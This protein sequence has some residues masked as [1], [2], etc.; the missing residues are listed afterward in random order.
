MKIWQTALE[1]AKLIISTVLTVSA[2][3]AGSWTIITNT[4]ITRSEAEAQIQNFTAEIA[5]NKAF[6]LETKI[7]NLLEIKKRRELSKLE[8]KELIRLRKY[9]TQVDNHLESI[10]LQMFGDK[11]D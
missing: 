6:R 3:A 4:F 9:L 11:K 8:A 2:L 7:S 1:N 5:Y 10:E